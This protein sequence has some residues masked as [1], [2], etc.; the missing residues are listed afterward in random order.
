[1]LL[2]II[3][4]VHIPSCSL[5]LQRCAEDK[6]ACC[7]VG[8]PKSVEN[9]FLLID[10]TFGFATAVEEAQRALEAAKVSQGATVD[11]SSSKIDVKGCQKYP[12][13]L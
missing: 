6:V 3:V 7:V 12:H 9:D 13:I 10:S 5:P 11:D 1:M 2:F 8:V 4:L